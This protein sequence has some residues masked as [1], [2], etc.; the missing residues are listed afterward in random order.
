MNERKDTIA[1]VG[2][3]NMDLVVKATRAPEQGETVSGEALYYLPGEKEPIRLLLLQDWVRLRTWLGRSV[4]MP[5]VN[6]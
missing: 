2:S 3:L 1:V 6:S 5:L 4:M